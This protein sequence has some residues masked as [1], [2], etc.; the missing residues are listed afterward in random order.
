MTRK[1]RKHRALHLAFAALIALYTLPACD[2]ITGPSK[3]ASGQL[4]QSGDGKYDPYFDAVHKEQIAAASWPD[5]SK[6]ARRPI[7]TALTLPPNASNGTIV[8][9]T[10]A[11]KEKGESNIGHAVEET[12]IAETELSKK[13]AV[14]AERLDEMAK[15]GE[16]LKKHAVED[17]RNMG[18]DKADEKKVEKKE[19]I[20][21]E[22]SAAVGV[23]KDLADDARKGSK[24]AEE[25]VTKLKAVWDIKEDPKK[26]DPPA[27]PPEKTEKPEKKPP[28]TP[29]EKKPAPKPAAK[30]EEKKPVAKP[31]PPEEKP[32]VAKPAGTQKPP[33]GEVFNP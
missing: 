22:M 3:V 28:A 33:E 14:H 9:A 5:E 17:R 16:E 19:Q 12:M 31:S 21:K 1:H 23:V 30:P 7:T 13:L 27:P 29:H 20:K 11:K 15:K 6:A 24:E 26:P 4:Y 25:L 32:P 18:A 8:S 2:F 10:K